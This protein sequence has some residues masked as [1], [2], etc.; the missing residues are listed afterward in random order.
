VLRAG[1]SVGLRHH[2]HVDGSPGA[3]GNE[4]TALEGRI[5]LCRDDH[6]TRTP[7]KR[8]QES[9]VGD[10]VCSEITDTCW[11]SRTG[12]PHTPH[13]LVPLSRRPLLQSLLGVPVWCALV[14]PSLLTC[15]ELMS[16]LG[17]SYPEVSSSLP[18]TVR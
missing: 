15:S 13:H 3:E 12:P 9:E 11:V 10:A 5:S 6:R 4:H 18:S 17:C 8:M 14:S 1:D 16:L 2:R 7:C